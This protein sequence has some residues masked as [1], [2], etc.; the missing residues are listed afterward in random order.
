MLGRNYC[1]PRPLEHKS[2]SSYNA[3]SPPT[4]RAHRCTKA[5][6]R[7]LTDRAASAALQFVQLLVVGGGPGSHARSCRRAIA[8]A[9]GIYLP[10]RANF[11]AH[12]EPEATPSLPPLL[13]LLLPAFAPFLSR[14]HF[15]RDYRSRY[16]LRVYSKRSLEEPFGPLEQ[17]YRI[18][19]WIPRAA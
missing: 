5:A 15:V 13:L 8:N 2:N 10:R 7:D 9:D 17:F 14:E 19:G 18:P 12:L 4:D 16:I 3:Y 11:R 1:F 6:L